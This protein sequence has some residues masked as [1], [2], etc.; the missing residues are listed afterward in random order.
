MSG[1]IFVEQ[2]YSSVEIFVTF[3]KIRHFRQKKFRPIRYQNL[4]SV[5]RGKLA[6]FEDH[7]IYWRSYEFT[8]YATWF[9][10][11][12]ASCQRQKYRNF[13]YYV[14]F[15]TFLYRWS[16]LIFASFRNV[17]RDLQKY[18]HLQMSLTYDVIYVSLRRT[19][20]G[21]V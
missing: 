19:M 4:R 20:N 6:K 7:H 13:L 18:R 10:N 3:K 5:K 17:D 14:D 2:N 16:V 21:M 11:F 9:Q 1:K 15:L 8:N 12:M